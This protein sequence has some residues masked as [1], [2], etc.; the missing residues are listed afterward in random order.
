MKK[1]VNFWYLAIALFFPVAISSLY[2]LLERNHQSLFS[3][4]PAWNDEDFYYNQI[5]SMLE[6]G[7]PLGYYGYN[8][9]HAPVGTFGAHGWFILLPY[10]VFCKIFGLQKKLFRKH[11]FL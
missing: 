4:M 1:K 2:L 10:V 7:R 5:K 8:G 9:S 11:L 3:I 6:Y